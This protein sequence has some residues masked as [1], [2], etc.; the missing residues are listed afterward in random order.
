MN[1]WGRVD[2]PTSV[3][4]F[5]ELINSLL[6]CPHLIIYSFPHLLIFFHSSSLPYHSSSKIVP[7]LPLEYLAEKRIITIQK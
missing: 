2:V 1:K 4:C 5:D 3:S 7:N 6:E